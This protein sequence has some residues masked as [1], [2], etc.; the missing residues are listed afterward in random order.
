MIYRTHWSLYKPVIEVLLVH[1][2][3]VIHRIRW[4]FREKKNTFQSNI[5]FH[6]KLLFV[7][8]GV[9]F[10]FSNSLWLYTHQL[11][12]KCDWSNIT[13][14]MFIRVWE[15]WVILELNFWFFFFKSFIDY[16]QVNR[17]RM[18]HD[19]R[20]RNVV[21]AYCVH[22]CN[23]MYLIWDEKKKNEINRNCIV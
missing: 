12:Q 1:L 5:G 23:R 6:K 13:Y 20:N 16:I 4:N 17:A 3:L 8:D 18:L 19:C 10:L 22:K 14:C 11:Q 7:V 2:R 9:F 21:H 15:R